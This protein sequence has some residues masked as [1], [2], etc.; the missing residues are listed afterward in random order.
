MCKKDRNQKGGCFQRGGG[1]TGKEHKELFE[2]IEVVYILIEMWV[3]WVN[4]F[5]KFINLDT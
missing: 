5:V 1:V 3:M 2:V 4:A